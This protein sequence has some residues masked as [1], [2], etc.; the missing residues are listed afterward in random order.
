M[1]E[2]PGVPKDNFMMKQEARRQETHCQFRGFGSCLLAKGL[3]TTES[4]TDPLR[5]QQP[6]TLFDQL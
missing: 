4:K 2:V 6:L 3:V 5:S 1:Q